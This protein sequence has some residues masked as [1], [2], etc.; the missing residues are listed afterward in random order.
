MIILCI[1]T[2][3]LHQQV[4]NH[5]G[6]N[7]GRTDRQA[8]YKTQLSTTKQS[9][10][11][12]KTNHAYRTPHQQARNHTGTQQQQGKDRSTSK[13]TA[14][15]P[16][17]CNHTTPR[18]VQQHSINKRNNHKQHNSGSGLPKEPLPYL[19][20][21]LRQSNKSTMKSKECTQPIILH[22][23]PFKVPSTINICRRQE[24]VGISA[25]FRRMTD[26]PN[27]LRTTKT[28]SSSS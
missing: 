27:S 17:V 16:G 13:Q 21:K 22:L 23:Q 2:I 12:R 24:C 9:P 20:Q 26:R 6:N 11:R 8:K 19:S 10:Y 18:S 4:R 7:K 3:T 15:I 14:R 28:A 5:T 25:S 1:S